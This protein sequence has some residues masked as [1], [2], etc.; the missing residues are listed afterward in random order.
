MAVTTPFSFSSARL[1]QPLTRADAA[2][3]MKRGRNLDNYVSDE[4]C[5]L[6]K[7]GHKISGTYGMLANVSVTPVEKT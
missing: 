6:R 4:S 5:E 7:G 2:H 1:A 3:L